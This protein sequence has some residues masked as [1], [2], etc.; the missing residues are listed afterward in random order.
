MSQ[1]NKCPICQSEL[2]QTLFKRENVPVH[3]NLLMQDQISAISILRGDLTIAV[4]E[5][6]GFIFNKDF[7]IAKLHYS[8]NYDNTQ[9]CS[10]MFNAYLSHLAQYLVFEKGIQNCRIVEIGCGKGLFLRKLV[11][12]GAGNI[13]YG[14]D[15]S[16]A[17]PAIDLEGRLHFE[18]C[19]YGPE[20][21]RSTADVIICRHV[22]EH[23]PN[24]T[25]FLSLIK[26]TLTN[27]SRAYIFFETPDVEWI[28]RNQVIWDFFYEHCSYFSS[29]SLMTTFEMSGFK[30][31]R[32]RPVF[33]EQYLWLESTLIP[34][35]NNPPITIQTNST[36]NIAK[37]FAALEME[38]EEKWRSRIQE[39]ATQGNIALWGAGAK[40]V[41]FA[42]LIDPDRQWITCI[43]D[44]NPQK[45][46][47][48]LPG[49]GHPIISYL[50][51]VKFNIKTAIL[52]NPNYFD[53]NSTL[54]H[55]AHLDVRLIDLREL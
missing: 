51:L 34:E 10:P 53:E 43:V 44:L 50:D 32:V 1:I 28:L 8:D 41:T 40:G 12:M 2:I 26:K 7:D 27:S 13:G 19:Y 17:G 23:I 9:S 37:Q 55:D 30:V 45:Q 47:R 29:S 16:Y 39:L 14:F 20:C 52:M 21:S 6:C 15:P 11:E 42:N 5:A 22:I 35:K 18:K 46:H 38:L 24:P 31:E 36:S 25:D 48:Y 54:L 3:Q 49:T 4:C 33:G